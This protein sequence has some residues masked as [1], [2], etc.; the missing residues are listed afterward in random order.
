M[1]KPKKHLKYTC[2]RKDRHGVKQ[3]FAILNYTGMDGKIKKLE[4]KLEKYTYDEVVL[5][6]EGLKEF[7]RIKRNR[8]QFGVDTDEELITFGQV[9]NKWLQYKKREVRPYTV[10]RYKSILNNHILPVL[11]DYPVQQISRNNII[12]IINGLCDKKHFRT[13]QFIHRIFSNFCKF[14]LKENFIKNSPFIDIQFPTYQ[15]AEIDV[16]SKLEAKHFLKLC[17]DSKHALLFEFAL[18]TGMRPEEYLA[19][20]WRDLDI[21]NKTVIVRRSVDLN[22][23]QTIEFQDVKS[24]NSRRKIPLP[25]ALFN[26]LIEFHEAQLEASKLKTI[27]KPVSKKKKAQRARKRPKKALAK[28]KVYQHFDLVFPSEN[29]TPLRINNLTRRYFQPLMEKVNKAKRAHLYMLRHTCATL[30]LLAGENPK[31][32]AERLGNSITITLE[33]YSHVL[34]NMQFSASEKLEKM[35]S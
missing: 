25:E 24:K 34:P 1:K 26:K 10:K 9:S 27:K 23:L 29:G 33:T 2:W 32:V 17:H 13:A 21:D 6:R 15:R 20:Q 8:D 4:I 3:P 28:P 14:A 16:L 11:K 22:L 12:E 5:A 18:M 31:I 7:L 30:L 19:L 35:L